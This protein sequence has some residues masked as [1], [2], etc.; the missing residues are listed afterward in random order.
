MKI[1]VNVF[2][3]VIIIAII[4][5]VFYLWETDRVDKFCQKI[6]PGMKQELFFSLVSEYKVK[7]VEIVGDDVLGGKWHATVRTHIPLLHYQCHVQGVSKLVVK[8]SVAKSIPS[9]TVQGKA[10]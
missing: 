6:T 8:A 10:N 1:L 2:Q 4:S 5:P 3:L 7:I 9:A